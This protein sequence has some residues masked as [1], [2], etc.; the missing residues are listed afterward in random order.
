MKKHFLI[1]VLTS[2]FSC[3]SEEICT[4]TDK[5]N[6]VCARDNQYRNPCFAKC[7]GYKDSEITVLLSQEE[8]DTGILI[9]VDC[10]L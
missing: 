4:C 10:S 3:K 6:P 5:Y 2:I 9:E 1:V 7:D 8:I